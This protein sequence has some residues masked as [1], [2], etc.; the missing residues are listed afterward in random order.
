MTD[1]RQI[2]KSLTEAQRRLVVDLIALEKASLIDTSQTYSVPYS[3]PGS[4]G[5]LVT[6]LGRAV[7]KEL[8]EM[9]ND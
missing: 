8:E 5:D 9:G 4:L 1:P 2:A 6:D 3:E 7:A